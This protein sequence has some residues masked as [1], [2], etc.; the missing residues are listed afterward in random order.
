MCCIVNTSHRLGEGVIEKS[1][2]TEDCEEKCFL[3]AEY[4]VI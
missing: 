1:A 4:T 2:M 3:R